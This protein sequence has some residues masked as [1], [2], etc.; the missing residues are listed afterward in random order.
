MLTLNEVPLNP[1]CRKYEGQT[2]I[3]VTMVSNFLQMCGMFSHSAM[4][5][6]AWITIPP[7]TLSYSEVAV[8]TWASSSVNM[9]FEIYSES[10]WF[11]TNEGLTKILPSSALLIVRSVSCGLDSFKNEISIIQNWH[12][13]LSLP[14]RIASTGRSWMNSPST[15]GTKRKTPKRSAP[16][17]IWAVS[18]SV[19]KSVFTRHSKASV[20]LP[21]LQDHHAHISACL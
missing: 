8:C 5:V 9:R 19:L 21:Q 10:V 14:W 18:S 4:A 16:P 2:K 1:W 15:T 3:A 17:T 20:E 12:T 6:F 13:P 11:S 7:E